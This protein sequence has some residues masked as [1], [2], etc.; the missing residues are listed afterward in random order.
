MGEVVEDRE[1]FTILPGGC[2]GAC[3]QSAKVGGLSPAPLLSLP[4]ITYC[5]NVAVK[6]FVKE[7]AWGFRIGAFVRPGVF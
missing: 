5:S 2:R 3:S 4:H 7:G 1:I 6:Q